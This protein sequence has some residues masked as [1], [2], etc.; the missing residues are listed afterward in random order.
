MT[1]RHPSNLPASIHQ[2]LLNQAKQEGRPLQ[3]LLQ[4]FVIER[5]LFRLSQSPHATKFYLKGALMLR[6]WDSPLSRPT[7][8]VDL[9]GQTVLSSDALEKT[10][11]DVCEQKVPDDGCLFDSSTVRAQAIRI[12]DHD[13]GIRVEFIAHIGRMR[14]SMQV[15]VGF[16]DV[17]VPGPVSIDFPV[18]LD[19][20]SP[21][22]LGYSRE[23]AI[24][25]KFQAMVI[26]D[27]AN[28]RMKDFYDIWL[29]AGTH[30][31][32]GTVLSQAITATFARRQTAFPI[33]VPTGLQDSFAEDRTKQTQWNAFVR[34]GRI[35]I[36]RTTFVGVVKFLRGFLMPPTLAAAKGL[37]FTD[38]WLPPGPWRSKR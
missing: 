15:D 23:S 4:Y 13:G 6:L 32:D 19:F 36:D 14:L 5:F 16:G 34:K 28:S 10:I 22:L 21:H 29:L 17:V 20:P 37:V 12:D 11:R 27:S 7:I 31:F 1:A 24:A 2:R 30:R 25:E 18:L 33:E 35:A 26:L 9:M 8:D 3:E 38:Q